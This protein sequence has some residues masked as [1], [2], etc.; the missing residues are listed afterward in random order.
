[1]RPIGP[2]APATGEAWRAS[3]ARQWAGQGERGHGPGGALSTGKIPAHE[4]ALRL[5]AGRPHFRA[6]LRRKLMARGYEAAE[7]DDALARCAAQGYLDDEATARA[8]VAERQERRGLGRARIAAELRRH[9]AT[10]EAIAAA[11]GEVSDDGD[12][13]RAR[14]AASRWRR[15][16]GEGPAA[17]AALARHLDRK[18]FS[19]RAIVAVLDQAG[20]ADDLELAD[21][22]AEPAD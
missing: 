14:A 15:H 8:F 19:R 4:R 21:A 20:A 12:L 1:M 6:D 17:K 13:E 2:E 11:L 3:G 22:D 9:G 5:L 18:G 10:A 7:V 16:G